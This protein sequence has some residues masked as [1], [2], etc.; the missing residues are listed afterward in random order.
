MKIVTFT[1]GQGSDPWLLWRQNGIGASDIGVLMGS[2]TYKTPLQLWDEKCGY[3]GADPINP[4]MAHGIKNEDVARQWINKNQQ[5]NLE[6]LCIEDI[7]KTYFKASLDGY[8]AET[9]TLSEIKCPVSDAI[10]DKAREYRSIPLY[11]QHQIQWQ[12]MLC[13]PTRAFIA[14][15][16]YRYE[17]C[18]TIEAFAQPTLQKEMKEKAEE[19]WRKVQ[20][21]IPPK[22]S[23]K[24]YV[25]VEDP[26]LKEL[27]EEYEDH[28]TVAKTADKRKKD[29]KKEIEEYGD[30][31][32]FTAYNFLITRCAP[33]I[34]YDMEQM[35][36]DGIEVDKYAKKNNSSGYYR[37]S[38]PK[39]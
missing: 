8:D 27:L 32:N 15:W 34:T 12:I 39:N 22:P 11:W 31:G 13:K 28:D 26:R 9:K 5:L 29:L 19:F 16:D 17:S 24:E 1:E 2:N 21:G 30:G 37:I 4:A 25:K 23:E 6:P 3:K 20:M 38:I 35:K 7:E 10:L 18:I 36:M 14:L 33:R